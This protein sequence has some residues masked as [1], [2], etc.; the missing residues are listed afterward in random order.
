VLVSAM[1]AAVI[2]LFI[3]GPHLWLLFIHR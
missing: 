3:F 1:L 2:G